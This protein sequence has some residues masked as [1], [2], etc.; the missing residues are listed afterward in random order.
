MNWVGKFLRLILQKHGEVEGWT[1]EKEGL[2]AMGN[3]TPRFPTRIRTNWFGFIRNCKSFSWT[4]FLFRCVYAFER[5][6][7]RAIYIKEGKEGAKREE[8]G[9]TVTVS[10]KCSCLF[11][12]LFF[13]KSL[14]TGTAGYLR[15]LKSNSIFLSFLK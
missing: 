8:I 3:F 10:T 7:E 5:E 12:F 1:P 11:S 4:G 9:A 6:R 14:G 15:K 13:E 2:E